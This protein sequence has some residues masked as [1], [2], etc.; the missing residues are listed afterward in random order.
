MQGDPVYARRHTPR[1]HRVRAPNPARRAPSGLTSA[2]SCWRSARWWASDA[3]RPDAA[4]SSAFLSSSWRAASA[5]G[6]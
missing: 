3:L 2:C 1:S 6:G 5:G 4:A